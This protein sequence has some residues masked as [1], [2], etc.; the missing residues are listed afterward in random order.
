MS[1]LSFLKNKNFYKHFAIANVI[2]LLIVVGL[3]YSIKL[4]TLHGQSVEV[5]DFKNLMV[6]DLDKF[7]AGMDLEYVIVDSTANVKLPKGIVLEQDPI[8][9]S[10]VKPGRKVYL[11]INGMLTP[12]VA[13]PNLIDLSIRQASSLIETYG[14]KLGN[15][16]YVSGLPPVL[17]QKHK[18]VNIAPGEMIEKDAVIDLVAG[19]GSMEEDVVLPDFFG[20]SLSQVKSR[21]ANMDL[22]LGI[23]NYDDSV[24]DTLK[25]RVYKQSPDPDLKNYIGRNQ[26]IDLWMTESKDVLNNVEVD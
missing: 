17:E 25:A 24:K 11:T 19:K 2:A 21:M 3:V 4:F 23:I 1:K 7:V 10:K 13:M 9:G 20:L 18:G 12:T 15:I 14:L 26:N 6:K 5:P 22:N 8:A 16:T